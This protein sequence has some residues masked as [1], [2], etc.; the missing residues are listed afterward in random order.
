M[1]SE[2]GGECPKIFHLILGHSR[3]GLQRASNISLSLSDFKHSLQILFAV[4]NQYYIIGKN[5][6]DI[7]TESW[8]PMFIPLPDSETGFYNLQRYF[9]CFFVFVSFVLCIALNLTPDRLSDL[10]PF[11]KKLG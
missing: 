4:G 3:R 11:S 9:S 10:V 7:I 5:K 8:F 1:R 6:K 2:F